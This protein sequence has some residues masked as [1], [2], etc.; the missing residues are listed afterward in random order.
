M[1]ITQIFFL[2]L[3]SATSVFA[4]DVQVKV[5]YGDD[6]RVDV[7]DSVNPVYISLAKST[8]AMVNTLLLTELNS[9][10]YE[11]AG[12]SLSDGGVCSSER[13]SN[14]PTLADCSGFLVSKDRLVTA[15]HCIK[16]KDDCA[17]SSWVFD[18]RVQ[19]E[20]DSKVV[21]DKSSVYKCRKI[22]SQKLD[23]ETLADYAVI[24]LSRDV[25]D[26]APLKFRASGKPVI[27]ESLVVIGH[28][29]GLPTKIADGASVKE[30]NDIYLT[31]N[32]D[33]YGGNSGS[34]VFNST[35]GIVEGI[36]VRGETDYIFDRA[37]GCRVSNRLTDI[38]AGEEVTLITVVKGLPSIKPPK[39]PKPPITEPVVVQDPPK[40]PRRSFFRRIGRF[41]RRLFS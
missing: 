16:T 28:P 31:S 20:S 1:N 27:G 24:E 10:Q 33:T 30:I 15:G 13:F 8:A 34:A 2:L 37:L 18:Y 22:I 36:L 38:D 40:R 29:S 41:F 32:L 19:V 23:S 3:F 4:S 14:Q 39:P 17:K 12:R 35:T 6:N 26:R 5:I 7:E 25:E 11:L 9:E 21:V